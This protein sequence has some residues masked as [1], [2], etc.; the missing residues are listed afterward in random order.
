VLIDFEILVFLE[1]GDH[2]ENG[3]SSVGHSVTSVQSNYSLT[4]LVRFKEVV[5]SSSVR[6]L[7]YN[8]GG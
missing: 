5:V 2:R 8:L 3:G 6:D 1:R 7:H 4:R